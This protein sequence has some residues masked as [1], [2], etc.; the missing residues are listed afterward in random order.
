MVRSMVVLDVL[1]CHE[2]IKGATEGFALQIAREHLGKSR[3]TKNSA[4]TCA[5]KIIKKPAVKAYLKK[6]MKQT[7]GSDQRICTQAKRV[8]EEL[9]ILSFSDPNDYWEE[10][11]GDDGNIELKMKPL[12]K[13]GKAA[14][15]IESIKITSDKI[16]KM[17]IKTKT[18]VKF[19]SKIE[20]LKKLGEHHKLYT[21]MVQHSGVVGH[22]PQIYL[23]DNGKSKPVGE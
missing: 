21:Q 23:P 20:A 8:I 2:L 3:L 19:H 10:V 6:L 18:E 17:V 7:H 15:A 14:R 16:G 12:G 9:D 13:M 1:F 11:K 22:G 4:Y 5:S